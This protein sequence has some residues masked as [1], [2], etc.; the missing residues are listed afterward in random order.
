MGDTHTR[1]YLRFPNTC[2][3]PDEECPVFDLY[4]S[5]EFPSTLKTV[6]DKN[7]PPSWILVRR[8]PCLTKADLAV[9]LLSPVLN[10]VQ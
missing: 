10:N 8:I 4:H 3:P 2:V 9:Y 1:S 5:K 7:S 6:V